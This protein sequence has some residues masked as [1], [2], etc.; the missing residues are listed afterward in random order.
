[1]ALP[2]NIKFDELKDDSSNAHLQRK[3]RTPILKSRVNEVE[4]DIPGRDAAAVLN[5]FVSLNSDS[6]LN[7]LISHKKYMQLREQAFMEH[8]SLGHKEFFD[9]FLRPMEDKF[10]LRFPDMINDRRDY[11]IPFSRVGEIGDGGYFMVEWKVSN[12]IVTVR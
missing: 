7:V 9:N 10:K 1:M 3:P 8:D 2:A 6:S 12:P 5:I 11:F 4:Q